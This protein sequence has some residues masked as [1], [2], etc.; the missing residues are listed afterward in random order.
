[1]KLPEII[2]KLKNGATITETTCHKYKRG[3]IVPGCDFEVYQIDGVK[4]STVQFDKLYYDLGLLQRNESAET[5]F[6]VRKFI[7]K[8]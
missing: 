6:L 4:I 8:N 7:Y 5:S 1:M 2:E 3:K